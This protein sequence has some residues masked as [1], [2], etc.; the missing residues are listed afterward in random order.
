MP[1][2]ADFSS[3][4]ILARLPQPAQSAIKACMAELVALDLENWRIT[5]ACLL[6]EFQLAERRAAARGRPH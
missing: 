5:L 4:D 6:A 1:T 3:P 2:L